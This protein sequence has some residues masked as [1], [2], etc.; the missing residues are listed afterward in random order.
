MDRTW[1]FLL[2]TGQQQEGQEGDH[3][4]SGVHG[5]GLIVMTVVGGPNDCFYYV[6]EGKKE[7]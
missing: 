7:K 5:H 1:R 4:E 6:E 2:K 3:V